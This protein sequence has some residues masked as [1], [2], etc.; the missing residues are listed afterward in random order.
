MSQPYT[1]KNGNEALTSHGGLA[2][3]GALLN[4]RTNL[5]ERLNNVTLSG[6]LSPIISHSDIV[7]SMTGLISLAK[8]DYDAIEPFREDD[9]FKNS[10][11]LDACPSS[12]A[13]R[14][15]LDLVNGDFNTIIKEESALLIRN[16][17][18]EITPIMTAKGPLIPLDVDVSPFDN[19]K[20]HKEGVSRTY[21]G[22]DGFAPNFAYLGQEGFLVNV[23]LREGKQHCQNGTPEFLREAITYCKKITF[24]PL[25]VRLDSGNDSVYNIQIFIEN[26]VDFIIK[27]NLRRESIENWLEVAKEKGQAHTPRPGKTVY[28]GSVYRQLPDIEDPVRIVFEITERTIDKNGQ[29]LLVPDIE[30]DTYWVSLPDSE[31]QVIELYHDHGTSEQYHSELKTDMDLE[32]FPSKYFETNSLILTIGMLSYNMLR[33]CG[34]E[35]LQS[36]NLDQRPKFR[37]AVSRRRIRTVIQDLIYLAGRVTSHSKQLYLSFGRYCHWSDVWQNI[38]ERFLVPT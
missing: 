31:S 1:V 35:S 4:N 8:P 11:S 26:K 10:L 16:T 36:I 33:L 30:I 32:R 5:K 9:F 7:F 12:P 29:T 37:K 38:Y 3:I 2:L 13:M 19:S 21:K 17:A 24:Q 22:H 14:Q 23:E 20:T 18:R 15:R 25:L 34:Q 28:Q 6:C 27:R